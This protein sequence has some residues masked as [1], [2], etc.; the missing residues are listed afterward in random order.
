MTLKYKLKQEYIRQKLSITKVVFI[1][2]FG[3]SN[4]KIYRYSDNKCK[5]CNNSKN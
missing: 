4:S 5:H 3:A 1:V 2:I